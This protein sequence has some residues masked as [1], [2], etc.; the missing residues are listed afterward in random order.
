MTP[1]REA[2]AHAGAGGA[3]QRRDRAPPPRLGNAADLAP[4]PGQVP[5]LLMYGPKKL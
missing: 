3:S 4:G 1:T 2:Q 5:Q